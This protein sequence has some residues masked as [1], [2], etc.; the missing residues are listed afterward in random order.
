MNRETL[1]QKKADAEK[2]FGELQKQEADIQKELLRVQGEY[3]TFEGLIKELTD[4]AKTID[5]EPTLK[6]ED[7]NADSN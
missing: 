5:A 6:K 7:K 4:P 3:R 1:E 2:R